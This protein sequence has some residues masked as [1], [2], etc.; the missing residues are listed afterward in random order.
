M[1]NLRLAELD[2]SNSY[3]IDLGST[4]DLFGESTDDFLNGRHEWNEVLSVW[5]RHGHGRHGHAHGMAWERIAQLASAD[6]QQA[7]ELLVT[8]DHLAFDEALLPGSRDRLGFDL[9]KSWPFENGILVP[10]TIP[11]DVRHT[12][13]A[14]INVHANDLRQVFNVPVDLFH[15]ADKNCHDHGSANSGGT[16]F[17]NSDDHPLRALYY[18]RLSELA[19][20]HCFMSPKK[21]RYFQY[22]LE[23]GRSKANVPDPHRDVVNAVLTGLQTDDDLVP[24]ITVLVI[25]EALKHEV[26]P[27]KALLRLR[28]GRE[29]TAYRARLS[30]LRR[31]ARIPILGTTAEV[32]TI[33]NELRELG[34]IWTR[35]PLEHTVYNTLRVVNA[36]SAIPQV[37]PLLAQVLPPSATRFAG[38]LARPPDQVHLFISRWFRRP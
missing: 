31:G 37:G 26:S 20:V 34:A 6:V 4:L 36:V 22:L 8:A 25:L 35:D 30:D 5:A 29:A 19:K 14:D 12:A 23:S 33:L 24:P 2:E 27:G 3:L 13:W 15:A 7:I 38:T 10:V 1:S 11:D 16:W 32:Q 18:L 28:A 21:R 17:A 9:S